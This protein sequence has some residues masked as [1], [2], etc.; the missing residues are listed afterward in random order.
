MPD[1]SYFT[2]IANLKECYLKNEDVLDS[3]DIHKYMMH[4]NDNR[5]IVFGPRLCER[6][7]HKIAFGH[8][9]LFI[10]TKNFFM[11]KTQ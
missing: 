1:C 7:K 2:Y 3:K 8:V 10:M 5:G 4:S 6:K 11:S 9:F